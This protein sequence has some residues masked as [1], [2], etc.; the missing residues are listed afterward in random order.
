MKISI[1]TICLNAEKTIERTIK[2]VLSQEYENVQYIV[3]DGMSKDNTLEIINK[4]RSNINIVISEKDNGISEAF[5]KGLAL[6]QGELIGILNSDDWYEPNALKNA[7]RLFLLNKKSIIHSNTYYWL[8]NGKKGLKMSSE[9]GI[10]NPFYG[11]T[12]R[13]PSC[14]I[15][16]SVY[17]KV[18]SYDMRLKVTMDYDF[19]IRADQQGLIF[20]KSNTIFTNYSEGGLSS[21]MKMKTLKEELFINGKDRNL[22]FI[23]RS[24][25]FSIRLIYLYFFD[26]WKNK[27]LAFTQ[28]K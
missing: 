6:A 16:M 22:N 14:F 11:C 24:L 2:S 1:I 26:H 21:K 12:I 20:K 17:K 28:K 5:N 19:F 27:L 3:I 9:I 23:Y 7:S 13:H 4:Y 18:G 8:K 25:I 10:K 15:P